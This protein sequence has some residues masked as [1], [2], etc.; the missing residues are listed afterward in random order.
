M[1]PRPSPVEQRLAQMSALWLEATADDA[2]RVVVWRIP[3]NADRM[4]QAFFESQR[5]ATE[6][7]LPDLF[8][9][10]DAPFETSFGY[11]RALNEALLESY[12]GSL[13]GFRENGISFNWPS[14]AAGRADSAAGF[15]ALFNSFAQHHA[16]H[17]RCAVAALMPS[18]ANSAAVW[19]DWVRSALRAGVAPNVRL[20]LVESASAP[21]WQFLRDDHAQ[22]TRTID[23]PIDMFDIARETAA[24]SPSNGPAVAYRQLFADVLTLVEKGTPAQTAA[25]AEHALKIAAREQWPDQQVALHMA[26][27]G[28][29]VKAQAYEPALARYRLAREQAELAARAR[30]PVGDNLVMQTWF[31]EAGVWL[32]A[33]QPRQAS[34]AYLQAAACA[35]RFGNRMLG[36]EGFRMAAFCDA[37]AGDRELAREHGALAVHEGRAIAADERAQTTLGVAL[38]DLLRLQDAP[39]AERI[40][41]LAQ[42]YAAQLAET[43]AEGERQAARLGNR[44]ADAAID[45][46]DTEMN[47]RFEA[48]F[49]QLR[50]QRERLIH[51]GDEYFRK[52]VAVGRELLQPQWCGLPEVKHPLD[53]EVAHWTRLPQ[54]APLPPPGDLTT[55][56]EAVTSPS[57]A[58]PI[59]V[60][61]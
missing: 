6:W 46:I 29:H 11:S 27:A 28:S 56:V 48:A 16:T 42:A 5:H 54:S 19:V 21:T 60:T 38:H 47:R 30:H 12:N 43:H 44:P 15:V 45:A 33:G 25:R 14:A 22:V 32:A 10:F 59:A 58:M 13:E 2:V 7:Q 18:A 52:V 8:V 20:A 17:F 51:G 3:D 61:P 57:N 23:A 36:L 35:Q 24:R 1:P 9:R 26:V 50:E 41:Q 40:E 53:T 49:A 34:L 4:L 39:R 31:G 55:A 37:R